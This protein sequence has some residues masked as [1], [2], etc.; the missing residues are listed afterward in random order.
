MDGSKNGHP[1]YSYHLETWNDPPEE[2]PQ[3]TVEAP[4]STNLQ[5]LPKIA[6]TSFM[7]MPILIF[8][9]LSTL[10]LYVVISSM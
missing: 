4:E 6:K 2:M 5:G 8:L 9:H 1:S 10:G 3:Q 7:Y